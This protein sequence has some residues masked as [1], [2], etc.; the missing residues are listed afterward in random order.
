MKLTLSIDKDQAEILLKTKAKQLGN[1]RP[2]FTNLY[3]YMLS[4]TLLTF[5]TLKKGGSFRG[6]TWK[7]F[8][9]QYTRK[10]GTRVPAEGGVAKMRGEGIVKGRLRGGGKSDVDRVD[11]GSNLL[12]HR[13]ILA[14]AALNRVHKTRQTM[15]MNTNV[16]YA[17]RQQAMRPFQFFELPKDE[18]VAVRMFHKYLGLA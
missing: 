17:D 16:D 12:R 8:A 14:N 13:G 2:F 5:R 9:D 4:R 10:G 3:S 11:A 1:L 7:W 18:D 6:V 15:V